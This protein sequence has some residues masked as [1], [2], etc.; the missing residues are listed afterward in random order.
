M[1][2][3]SFGVLS[4]VGTVIVYL[5]TWK[6][7]TK[8]N[9]PIT[10]PVFM[11]SVIIII[12]LV[13]FDIPYDTFMIGGEWINQLLGPAVVALAYPLY[14]QRHLLKQLIFPI[15]SG[16]LVGAIVGIFTGMILA[17]WAGVD[18][19]I[20]YSLIPKS[21]TTPVSIVIADSMGGVMSLT[22]VFVVIAGIGG[23]IMSP[24][25]FRIFNIKHVIG[26][27]VGMGSASH[28]IG[29]AQAMESSQLEGS[30]STIAMVLS[31]VAVSFIAPIMVL[32]MM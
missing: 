30:V 1:N 2:S 19:Y 16:T 27:G 17:I 24:F 12:G 28:A 14:Q 6:L 23:A 7:H 8:I 11:G 9:S 18:N 20:I 10:L 31:A 25:L 3:L 32:L 13:I 4:I 15:L 26:R 29:T 22:A 5:F 21:V